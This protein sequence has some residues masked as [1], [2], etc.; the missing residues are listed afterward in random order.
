M[1]DTTINAPEAVEP[2]TTE[3]APEVE[4]EGAGS[5]S[6]PAEKEAESSSEVETPETPAAE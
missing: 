3:V 4:T 2:E 6:A 5:T 1:D